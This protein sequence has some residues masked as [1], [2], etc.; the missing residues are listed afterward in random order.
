M[1]K[2]SC[3]RINARRNSGFTLIELLVVIA[4]IAILAA[5]LFPVFAQ[6][7][8]K[9]RQTACLSNMKQIGVAAA[10]Y[11]QDF[12]EVL[13]LP[14]YVLNPG[15][16]QY[17]YD[18]VLS[19]YMGFKVDASGS[20]PALIWACP[21]DN[22]PRVGGRL[23]RS[24]SLAVTRVNPCGV[25]SCTGPARVDATTVAGYAG[26]GAKNDGQETVGRSL[27]EITAPGS[28]FYMVET[29]NLGDTQGTVYGGQ[30]FYPLYTP[31]A[32]S[33]ADSAQNF[34]PKV[35][36]GPK[37]I[38][39]PTHSG[40][41]NYLYCDSHVKWSKPESTLGRNPATGA[42]NTNLASPRGP[43]T[44]WEGDD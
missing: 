44:V 32:P 10:G 15:N 28:T 36:N 34:V 38:I 7:R 5:I 1:L 4:I 3:D 2:I 18:T 35:V 29:R 37:V 26:A 39:E 30:V 16:V 40:G 41:W 8:D 21:N 23:A 43:W 19:P 24:Y 12:D 22:E 9:A 33:W 31:A 13:P 14:G 11:A 6:A 20:R 27:A 17:S 42:P 25:P